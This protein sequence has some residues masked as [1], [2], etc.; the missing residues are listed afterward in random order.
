ME[1]RTLSDN[2]WNRTDISPSSSPV[3]ILT[4]LPHLHYKVAGKEIRCLPKFHEKAKI[5]H[6]IK[7]NGI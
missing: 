6:V 4:E 5:E 2:A 1:E 7:F 3:T